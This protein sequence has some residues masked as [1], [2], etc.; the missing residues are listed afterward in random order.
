MPIPDQ[1]CT[2]EVRKPAPPKQY[3]ENGGDDDRA[4]HQPAR[5]RGRAE[6]SGKNIAEAL[7]RRRKRHAGRLFQRRPERS[8][9]AA[10]GHVGEDPEHQQHHQRA[11]IAAA[12]ARQVAAGAAAREHHAE[13][14]HQPAGDVPSPIERG[15]QIHR[16]G[17]ID[18]PDPMQNLRAQQ[19]GRGCQQPGPEAPP[20]A[21]RHD[22]GDRAHG[23]EVGGEDDGPE[24]HAD[25]EAADRQPNRSVRRDYVAQRAHAST[26]TEETGFA[27]S[28]A[29]LYADQPY[30][31]RFRTPIYETG[32]PFNAHQVCGVAGL[33]SP[34]PALRCG[35]C[36]LLPLS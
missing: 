6:R 31:R 21:Q 18:R 26:L 33:L 19:C 15:R 3:S 25:D 36:R 9:D 28:A 7:R 35:Y 32:I 20:V 29:R 23:A 12:D 11:Q 17:E 34:F 22:V 16:C 2:G 14:E 4:R 10:H 1:M 8:Q 5:T 24:G 27:T 30:T 13:A